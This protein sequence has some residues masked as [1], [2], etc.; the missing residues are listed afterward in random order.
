MVAAIGA[1]GPVPLG[2][3]QGG[4]W[5]V[6]QLPTPWCLALLR[7]LAPLVFSGG[8]VV[9]PEVIGS[10]RDDLAVIREEF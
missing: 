1:G 10:L 7:C 4:P 5:T 6:C 8:P 9:S 2:L 3:V